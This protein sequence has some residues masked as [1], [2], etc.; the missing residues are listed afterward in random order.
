[1]KGLFFSGAWLSLCELPLGQKSPFVEPQESSEKFIPKRE[2]ISESRK[3]APFSTSSRTETFSEPLL[4]Y[5]MSFE[6][7][8]KLSKTW[9]PGFFRV[10]YLEI[11]GIADQICCVNFLTSYESIFSFKFRRQVLVSWASLCSFLNEFASHF[12]GRL[13]WNLPFMR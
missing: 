1:M 3:M 13:N 8:Q 9:S 7:D 12:G 4:P 6:F 5:R 10:T 11:C 2:E